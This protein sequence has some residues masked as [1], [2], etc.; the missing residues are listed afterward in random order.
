MN[1]YIHVHNI[2]HPYVHVCVFVRL[3]ACIDVCVYIY[4]HIDINSFAEEFA[5]DCYTKQTHIQGKVCYC[6]LKT[7]IHTL[8]QRMD[9]SLK[10]P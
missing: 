6:H 3:Y 2:S 5:T 9:A 7:C 1:L 8:H 4:I 10:L